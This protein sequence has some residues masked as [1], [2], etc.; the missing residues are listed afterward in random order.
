MHL[1]N[2]ICIIGITHFLEFSLFL[3]AAKAFTIAADK[4]SAGTKPQNSVSLVL[5][6]VRMTTL[7]RPS[8]SR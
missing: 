3:V 1:S 7:F 2:Q 6:Y 8:E 5:K 4:N